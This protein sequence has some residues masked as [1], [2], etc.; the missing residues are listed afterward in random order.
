MGE[1]YLSL[2]TLLL[3]FVLVHEFFLLLKK[4]SKISEE[5]VQKHHCL[6]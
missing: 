5:G 3:N 2:I 6:W 4:K 1:R